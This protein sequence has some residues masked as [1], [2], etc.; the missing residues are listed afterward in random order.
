[1]VSNSGFLGNTPSEMTMASTDVVWLQTIRIGHL[2]TGCF[3]A[4]EQ[5]RR[6]K[7]NLHHSPGDVQVTA[8]WSGLYGRNYLAVT[9]ATFPHLG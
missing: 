3:L 8:Q 2:G 5:G 4:T 7:N 9:V 1:M 6:L